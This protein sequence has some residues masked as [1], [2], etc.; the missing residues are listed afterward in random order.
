MRKY[1]LS[2]C[3]LLC[4]SGMYAQY[5]NMQKNTE[6]HYYVQTAK[7]TS[8]TCTIVSDVQKRNDSTF[9]TLAEPMPKME[10]QTEEIQSQ[11]K[12]VYT[13]GNTVV[14]LQDSETEKKNILTMVAG[15]TENADMTKIE[16]KFSV[17]GDAYIILNDKAKAGDKIQPSKSTIKMGPVKFTTS[18][19]GEYGGHETIETPAGRFECLKV[20]YTAKVRFLL[21]SDTSEVTGWY[22][23]GVGLVKQEETSKKEDFRVVKTLSEIKE[24]QTASPDE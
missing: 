3:F 15:T 18:I 4:T 21:F 9:I 7:G 16:D 20:T 5:C 12:I 11:E 24:P 14:Y 8:K 22:A 23:K 13:D 19:K 2:T 6:L 1:I 17:K 10:G